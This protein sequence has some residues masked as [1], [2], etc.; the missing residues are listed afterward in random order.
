VRRR[1]RPATEDTTRIIAGE[2]FLFGLKAGQRAAAFGCRPRPPGRR[3]LAVLRGAILAAQGSLVAAA[4][5]GRP[6]TVVTGQL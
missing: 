1:V 3:L 5:L 2:E 4:G 6:V